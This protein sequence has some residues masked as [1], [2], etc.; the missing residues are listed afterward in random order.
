VLGLAESMASAHADAR[1]LPDALSRHPV[2]AMPAARAARR[3][4]LRK[5]RRR[6]HPPTVRRLLECAQESLRTRAAATD[7]DER[8]PSFDDDLTCDYRVTAV[9]EG[10]LVWPQANR[11]A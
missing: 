8:L 6:F 9:E 5:A 3:H 10:G 7:R 4:A 1:P 2:N 11:R